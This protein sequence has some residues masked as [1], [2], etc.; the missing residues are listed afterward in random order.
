MN[1]FARNM[2]YLRQR[3]RLILHWYNHHDLNVDER[4]FRKRKHEWRWLPGGPG[5]PGG[6]LGPCIP[7]LPGGPG[8]PK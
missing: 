4:E 3:K 6:P 2:C 8:G 1:H 7:C 5:R